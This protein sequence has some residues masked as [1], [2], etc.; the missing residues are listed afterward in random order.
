MKTNK[1]DSGYRVAI[2]H[3]S[4]HKMSGYNTCPQ[5]SP[6]CIAAC[7]NTAGHG[8]YNSVQE[9]RI[10]RT[11]LF[12][13]QRDKFK[14][15]LFREIRN[16]IKKN[17]KEGLKT[18]IRLN[19]TSDIRWE[20]VMPEVFKEFPNVQFYDYTKIKAKALAFAKK[21]L[22]KNYHI[23]FSKSEKNEKAC[24]EVIK[25]GCNVAVVFEELPKKWKGKKVFNADEDD[26]RFLDK[27]GIQ[28]LLAKG[29]AKK[30]D[31]GFVIRTI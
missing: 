3:L 11:K 2:M 18:A 21:K 6:G 19:G 24:E 20:Q 15:Q 10:R 16:F 27:K 29:K 25:A 4:P 5:A 28:G 12:F 17:D 13:E 26:L 31:T 9:A 7:L 14:E 22:P 23:T 1:K 8:A 30:D